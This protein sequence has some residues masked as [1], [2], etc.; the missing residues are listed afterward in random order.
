MSLT[1]ESSKYFEWFQRFDRFFQW[2]FG[3]KRYVIS[4]VNS[5]KQIR[6]KELCL[7]QWFRETT[8]LYRTSN[9]YGGRKNK[10]NEFR[11]QISSI[12]T[13]FQNENAKDEN[14]IMTPWE[15]DAEEGGHIDYIGCSNFLVRSY[16]W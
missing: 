15:V 13:I 5:T 10:F 16:E 12:N 9:L 11:Q 8:I 3:K 6:D 14:Q 7:T 4:V 2:K 1:Q